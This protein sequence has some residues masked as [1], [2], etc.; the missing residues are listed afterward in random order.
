M[1]AI[2]DLINAASENTVTYFGA[3][4]AHQLTAILQKKPMDL[5]FQD[6]PPEFVVPR[7]HPRL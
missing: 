1:I 3:Y 5:K 4:C 7:R 2:P 6:S